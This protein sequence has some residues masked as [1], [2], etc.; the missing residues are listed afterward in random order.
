MYDLEPALK[1]GFVSALGLA[2]AGCAIPLPKPSGKPTTAATVAEAAVTPREGAGAIVVARDRQL[3]HG[4]C[5]YEVALDGAPVATLRPGEQVTLYA[6]PGKRLV[7]ISAGREQ[8]CDAA[9][10]QLPIDVV[11]SA[12]TQVR[13]RSDA[14]YDLKVEATTY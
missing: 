2:L 9:V 6:D 11:A 3:R 12:T 14:R 13:V 8:G 5:S 4:G 10:A 1:L 7:E